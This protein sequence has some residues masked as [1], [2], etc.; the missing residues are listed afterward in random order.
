[1]L[2]LIVC[3]IEEAM[4]FLCPLAPK[5]SAGAIPCISLRERKKV[6]TYINTSSRKSPAL[7]A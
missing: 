6:G 2:R 5:G 1:V 7:S 4:K 3:G